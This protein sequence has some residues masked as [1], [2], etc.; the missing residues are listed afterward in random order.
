MS[1]KTILIPN[2]EHVDNLTNFTNDE[3]EDYGTYR[4]KTLNFVRNARSTHIPYY[5]DD[6][7]LFILT[8]SSL[9]KQLSIVQ[10]NY[11]IGSINDVRQSFIDGINEYTN[12]L[13]QHNVEESQMLFSRYILCTFMDELINTTY[14]GQENNWAGNSL[15]RTFHNESYGGENFFRLLDKFLKAPAK[16][17]YI[18]ELMYVCLSLGFQGKYRVESMSNQELNTIRESLYKQIKI[19]QGRESLKFYTRHKPSILR[20]R[21]FYI[22]TYPTIILSSILLLVII[23]VGLSVGLSEENEKFTFLINKEKSVNYLTE[24]NFDLENYTKEN[25]ND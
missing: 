25:K 14:F 17:I 12:T 2:S 23:Y 5:N 9:F 21:L 6:V 4:D 16:F 13:M 1:S 8:S 11:K 22:I 20:H 3:E 18:L 19:I 24:E 15:L 10:G 7:N